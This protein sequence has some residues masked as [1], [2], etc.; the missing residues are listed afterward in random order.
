M[1][2]HEWRELMT[3]NALAAIP[4]AAANPILPSNAADQPRPV[5]SSVF[6][7]LVS[8]VGRQRFCTPL[9]SSIA[10]YGD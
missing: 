3:N 9:R 8:S 6:A 10:I 2:S 1:L 7:V 5:T 4:K